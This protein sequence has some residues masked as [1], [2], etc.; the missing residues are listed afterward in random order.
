MPDTHINCRVFVTASSN[1]TQYV[2]SRSPPYH[3]ANCEDMIQE[4]IYRVSYL[5]KPRGKGY[6]SAQTKDF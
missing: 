6:R 2:F 1:A 4:A 3:F 5:A